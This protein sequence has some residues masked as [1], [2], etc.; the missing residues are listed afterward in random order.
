M[1]YEKDGYTWSEEP[2][3]ELKKPERVKK[4]KQDHWK[5]TQRRNQKLNSTSSWKDQVLH[6]EGQGCTSCF[7]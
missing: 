1:K 7:V 4:I 2:L 6:A 3:E 5:R